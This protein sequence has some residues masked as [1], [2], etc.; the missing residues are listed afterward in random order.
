[1]TSSK[2]LVTFADTSN[3]AV[4]DRLKQPTLEP[5]PPRASSGLVLG[6]ALAVL[7]AGFAYAMPRMKNVS[8]DG[9]PAVIVATPTPTPTETPFVEP[10]AAPK[11]EEAEE[12]DEDGDA[13]PANHGKAVST[14]AHCDI[15][16]R[17]HGELVRSIARDKDATVADAEAA[18]AAALAA[19]AA[20]PDKGKPATAAKAPK[21]VKPVKTE[22]APKPVK[23][24]KTEKTAPE[25]PAPE[26]PEKPSKP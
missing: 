20:S 16:G 24:V 8:A 26:K 7:A 23:P 21:P 25:K 14:A 10:T 12:T 4:H 1:M 9:D 3:M 18:C 15:K 2:E 6:L 22:T 5:A 19:Q 17:T 13:K 11:E